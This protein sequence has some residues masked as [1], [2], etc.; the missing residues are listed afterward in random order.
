[1]IGHSLQYGFSEDVL[2]GQFRNWFT[3]SATNVYKNDNTGA[4]WTVAGGH[5]GL[6][7]SGRSICI[8]LRLRP[9]RSW[10]KP[11]CTSAS[12]SLTREAMTTGTRSTYR[13]GQRRE[14]RSTALLAVGRR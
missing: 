10:P 3:F 13:M 8:L 1:M 11:L 4:Q 2:T 14:L 9:S 5:D 12:T 7:E 6:L